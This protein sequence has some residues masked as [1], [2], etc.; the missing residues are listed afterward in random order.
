MEEKLAELKELQNERAQLDSRIKQVKL[1]IKAAMKV[2]LSRR[3]A[4]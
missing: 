2:A 3:K 1:D 4:Q